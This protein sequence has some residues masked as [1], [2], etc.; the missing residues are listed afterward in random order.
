MKRITVD[1]ADELHSEFKAMTAKAG[2][3]ISNAIRAFIAQ[4][5]EPSR[6]IRLYC[7]QCGKEMWYGLPLEN[8]WKILQ[9][10]D[11]EEL[12]YQLLCSDCLLAEIKEK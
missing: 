8:I 7:T 6:S 1:I 4:R 9:Q 11:C 2:V 3:T 5:L 12:K 10:H